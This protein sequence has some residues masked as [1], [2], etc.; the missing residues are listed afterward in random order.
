MNRRTNQG[1]TLIEL[2]L[3]I[4]LLGILATVALPQFFSASETTAKNNA[5]E[6]VV[7]AVNT[8]LATYAAQQV[9]Q[10]S[11]VSYPSVLDSVANNTPASLTN[12]LFTNVL[13]AGV[14]SS[15]WRKLDPDCYQF[16][17]GDFF[18]YSNTSSTGTFLRVAVACN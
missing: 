15:F 10:G 16:D 5:K 13:K 14:T 17:G 9:S 11:G 1:F 12:P 4:S 3:V 7:A 2:V 18:Q 8:G 6:A